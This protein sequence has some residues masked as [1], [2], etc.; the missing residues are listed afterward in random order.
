MSEPI[1]QMDTHIII[2]QQFIIKKL[3]AH[4]IC[5]AHSLKRNVNFVII[6]NTQGLSFRLQVSEPII[7]LDTYYSYKVCK[8]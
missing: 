1:T 6:A 8:Q 5:F 3:I 4:M 7:H 2:A